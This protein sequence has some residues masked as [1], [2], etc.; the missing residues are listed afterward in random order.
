[1]PFGNN[2]SG[3][4]IL[5]NEI[6]PLHHLREASTADNVSCAYLRIDAVALTVQ[7]LG[8]TCSPPS[9]PN[10]TISSVT[11]GS[12]TGGSTVTVTILGSG[13]SAGMAVSFENGSGKTPVVSN[14]SVVG[15][16][17]INCTVTIP[18]GGSLSDPVWDIRVGPVVKPDAFRVVR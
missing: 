17:Q 10:V 9:D 16:T 2:P 6:D 8:T 14:V 3:D 4:Y 12:A 15:S 5:K 7:V 11:P 1:L 13:F 18:T